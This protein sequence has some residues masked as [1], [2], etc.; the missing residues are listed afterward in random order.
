MEHNKLTYTLAGLTLA[1]ALSVCLFE[2][3][4]ISANNYSIKSSLVVLEDEEIVE[5][6]KPIIPPPPPPPPPVLPELVEVIEDDEIINKPVLIVSDEVDININVEIENEPEP[7]IEVIFD[8]VEEVPEFIGGI[9]K[10]YEYLGNSIVYPAQAKDFSIQG[11]VFV[12]FVVW[13]DG[14]I[15]DVKVVKGSHKLLNNEALRVINNM[16]KWKPGKQR[17]KNVNARFTLPIKFRIS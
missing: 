17:G 14:A 8:V 7:E 11:K 4:T 5:I 12:Q 10:L 6:N 3:K 13:K 1:L 16:P 15:R 2:Y 9:E